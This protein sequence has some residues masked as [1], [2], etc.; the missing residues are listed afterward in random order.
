MRFRTC[1]TSSSM[2]SWQSSAELKFSSSLHT[3]GKPKRKL[4]RRTDN[5]HAYGKSLTYT[6]TDTRARNY[7]FRCDCLTPNKKKG[8]LISAK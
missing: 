5:R 1:A 8:M 3:V 6:T 7:R 2:E 4:V